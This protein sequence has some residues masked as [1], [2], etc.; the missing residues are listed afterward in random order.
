MH[1][2]TIPIW[3]IFLATSGVIAGALATGYWLGR[4]WLRRGGAKSDMSGAMVSAVM[5][6]LAFMLAF[7]FN[8]AATRH[9]S[10]RMLVLADA[11]AIEKTW[12]RAAFLP[13]PQRVEMRRLLGE[14]L[15]LRVATASGTVALSS[16]LPQFDV[17]VDRMWAIAADVGRKDPGSI[18]GGLFVESLNEMID[19]QLRRLTVAVRNRVAPTIWSVLYALTF[20]AMLMMG[21]QNGLTGG[22]QT[23]IEL[24]LALSFSIVLFL[25]ADLDRPQ[26]GLVNVS[27]QAMTE[28]QAKLRSRG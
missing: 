27:Q 18:V 16:A 19:V 7:T 24:A 4:W 1:F 26:E 28:L 15:D 2:D 9:E 6:L 11:T 20:I 10:R 23:G 3:G 21:I 25:I 13:E 17:L 8:A 5:G 12:L 14:Y 22:R